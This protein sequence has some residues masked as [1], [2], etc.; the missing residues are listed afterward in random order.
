MKIVAHAHVRMD[1]RGDTQSACVS[2]TTPR[3][4]QSVLGT[5]LLKNKVCGCQFVPYPVGLHE[6]QIVRAQTNPFLILASLVRIAD[7]R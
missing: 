5:V 6:D 2:K 3:K 1:A 4:Y 7:T